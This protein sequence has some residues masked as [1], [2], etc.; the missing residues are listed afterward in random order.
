MPDINKHS[1][2]NPSFDGDDV[3]LGAVYLDPD[4]NWA[5]AIKIT[6][7][8]KNL[9]VRA[10]S[11]PGGGDACVD[12]NYKAF[13]PKVF[14]GDAMPSG[15][16]VATMK[17]GCIRPELNIRRVLGRGKVCEFI[18]G[19]WSD[20]SHDPVIDPVLN[21]VPGYSGKL[22]VICLKSDRPKFITGSGPYEFLFPSPNLPA[23]GLI[24]Y[25]FETLRRW[26]MFREKAN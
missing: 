6:S 26:G 4:I 3:D 9:T 17:G 13:E 24:V 11:C 21:A 19:D 10:S 16:F 18:L 2:D 12:I 5:S 22:R 25:G 7:A 20:Q 1:F 8:V 15:Q 23:H 14:I